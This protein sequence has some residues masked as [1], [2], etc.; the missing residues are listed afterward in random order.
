MKTFC[1]ILNDVIFRMVDAFD[2]DKMLDELEKSTE[3]SHAPAGK[4][5][6]REEQPSDDVKELSNVGGEETH[7]NSE[8]VMRFSSFLF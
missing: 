8:V 2:M 7:S 4:L 5:V 3:D 1:Y 6:E